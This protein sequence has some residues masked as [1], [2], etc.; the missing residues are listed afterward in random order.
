MITPPNFD[1]DQPRSN[2]FIST[3]PLSLGTRSLPDL[4][5]AFTDHTR[6]QIRQRILHW[7]PESMAG[8]LEVETSLQVPDETSK[9][10]S[11]RKSPRTS[12]YSGSFRHLAPP[13]LPRV[14][15]ESSLTNIQ[16]S[17][18]PQLPLRQIPIRS[19]EHSIHSTRS[20][21]TSYSIPSL[22]LSQTEFSPS[23]STSTDAP[24]MTSSSSG[25]GTFGSKSKLIIHSH[26]SEDRYSGREPVQIKAFIRGQEDERDEEGGLYLNPLREIPLQRPL[27]DK[28]GTAGGNALHR[29]I[30]SSSPLHLNGKDL[31]MGSK[32]LDSPHVDFRATVEGSTAKSYRFPI[33]PDGGSPL[34][35]DVTSV[36][37][38]EFDKENHPRTTKLNEKHEEDIKA[39]PSP[40]TKAFSSSRRG[41]TA[42]GTDTDVHSIFATSSAADVYGRKNHQGWDSFDKRFAL[43]EPIRTNFEDKR[44][45]ERSGS[46]STTASKSVHSLTVPSNNTTIRQAHLSYNPSSRRSSLAGTHSDT[47][48][49]HPFASRNSPN[50]ANSGSFEIYNHHTGMNSP[51]TLG[52]ARGM[53]HSISMPQV[54]LVAQEDMEKLNDE[55]CVICCESLN[56]LYRLAG[57]RPNVTSACGHSLHHVSAK[58]PCSV[59]TWKPADSVRV[60]FLPFR[61]H[62]SP[63]CMVPSN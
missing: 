28:I 59:C 10:L 6:Q 58:Q 3:N 50:I 21:D 24:P 53:T 30:E 34:F 8:Y 44:R 1:V 47:G 57:E 52:S 27:D 18:P 33:T 7:L 11:T 5:T 45:L 56:P 48:S 40:K 38:K 16:F 60:P 63:R 51:G 26:H 2:D 37:E 42:S 15:E 25:S 13:Q 35:F 22:A 31:D 49:L 62:V 17:S 32:G 19:S 43:E 55:V 4:E 41:T 46:I 9:E 54:T 20:A 61:R 23:T 12:T 14:P 36:L 39:D 29:Q